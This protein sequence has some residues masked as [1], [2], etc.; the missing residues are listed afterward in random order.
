MKFEVNLI[1]VLIYHTFSSLSLWLQSLQPSIQVPG[2]TCW[3]SWFGTQHISLDLPTS[4]PCAYLSFLVSVPPTSLQLL[5]TLKIFSRLLKFGKLF[6][7]D[8]ICWRIFYDNGNPNIDN[9]TLIYHN[10]MY[11]LQDIM[12]YCIIMACSCYINLLIAP[13]FPLSYPGAYIN[14]SKEFAFENDLS[15]T[16]F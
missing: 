15:F 8:K 5:S 1:M 16:K 6:S 12:V 7:V 9:C 11:K 13:N 2:K 10:K 3:C 4:V 14:T